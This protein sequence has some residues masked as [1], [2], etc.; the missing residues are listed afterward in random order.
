MLPLA[1]V[2]LG[3][4]AAQSIGG[5]F[6]QRS[7]ARAENEA[8]ARQYRQ[9]LKI[10]EQEQLFANQ[11]YQTQLNQYEQEIRSIDEAAA[12]GYSRAQTQRNEAMKAASFQTQD[13]LI[14]LARNEG[15]TGASG[16]AGKSAQR[17]DANV[18]ASF[19][20]GQAKLAESM[21]SGQMA[22][23]QDIQDIALQ[24]RG[25]RNR[26]YSQVAIAP[27]K[28]IAPLAPTQVDGPS[29]LDLAFNL[30]QDYIGAKTLD[31]SLYADGNKGRLF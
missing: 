26:A 31:N 27:Q 14:Q 21:L 18:M 9:Q 3:L 6:G 29:P 5:F 28:R 11:L 12:L 2:S 20:R 23:E 16:M 10:Y 25:A 8:K 22:M 15:A 4:G 30:G 19:G 7:E 24:A 17:L 13:R 1:A